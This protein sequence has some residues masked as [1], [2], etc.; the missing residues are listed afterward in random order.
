[1]NCYE[2]HPRVETAVAICHLCG[3]GLC[4]EH[5]VWQERKVYGHVPSGMAA[6]VKALDRTL[7]RIVCAECDTAVG[8]GDAN[9]RA[10]I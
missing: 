9:G 8:T 1:M 7:P 5:A 6:Q 3:K 10:D 2:C 4:R